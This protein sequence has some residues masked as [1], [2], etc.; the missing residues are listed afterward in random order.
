MTDASATDELALVSAE[1]THGQA[2]WEK[3]AAAVLRKARKLKDTDADTEVWASLTSDSLAGIEIP[4]L[5]TPALAADLPDTGAPGAAPFT[6]G[7]TAVRPEHGWDI[8]PSYG[9]VDVRATN[10]AV[11]ADLENGATSVWLTLTP[12]GLSAENLP[13]ALEGVL[14]DLAPVVL[15]SYADPIDAAQALVDLLAERGVTPAEGTNLG[16]DPIAALVRRVVSTSSTTEEARPPRKLDHRRKL[17]RRGP[18]DR[19]PDCQGRGHARRG[20][21]C[22]CRARPGF[23]GVARARLQHGGGL[24]VPADPDRGGAGD[25]RGSG[26]DRVPVRRDRRPV[27]D[28]RQAESCPAGCG[29]GSASSAMHPRSVVASGSMP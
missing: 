17:D 19:R 29:T 21:G 25:R 22:H 7:R 8:R 12:G 9:G 28:D 10:E 11:L 4:P 14:L 2:E 3:T 16:A 1:D 20:R 13:A 18:H 15:D 23:V 26:A 27:P 24:G 6:R 5:G